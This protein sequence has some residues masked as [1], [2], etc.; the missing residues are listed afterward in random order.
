MKIREIVQTILDGVLLTDG[1]LSHHIRRIE[2]DTIAVAPSADSITVNNDE[3]VI[4]RV[5][6][7][8]GRT[9]GDGKAYRTEYF[10]DVNYYY[11]YNKTDTRVK[12]AATRI[13]AIKAA[14]LADERFLI[15]NDESDLPDVDTNYR[16]INVE[17]RFIGVETEDVEEGSD[18]H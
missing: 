3:Y 16:G 9:Y 13:K 17:F 8:R 2:T 18:E 7:S 6:S 14:F 1:V 4:Y 11:G 12:D 15:A 5:V 10:V